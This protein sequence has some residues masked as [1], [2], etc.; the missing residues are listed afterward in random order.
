MISNNTVIKSLRWERNC[1]Q[2][3]MDVQ[4]KKKKKKSGNRRGLNFK[5]LHRLRQ[6]RN[7]ITSNTKK[8]L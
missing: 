3:K 7:T 6:S 5:I 2:N 8:N 4:R 1:T